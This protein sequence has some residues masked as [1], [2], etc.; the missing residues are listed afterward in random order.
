MHCHGSSF[1]C[2]QSRRSRPYRIPD[3]PV[4][5]PAN[6]E[7]LQDRAENPGK[8]PEIFMESDIK[9]SG[10]QN[11]E[12]PAEGACRIFMPNHSG[13]ERAA[14]EEHAELCALYLLASTKWMAAFSIFFFFLPPR[15][16]YQSE[17]L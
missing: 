10:T 11:I 9:I 13:V 15:Q 8:A 7:Y 14:G 1:Q 2:F 3:V 16:E 5:L 4:C 17:L 12:R 6:A